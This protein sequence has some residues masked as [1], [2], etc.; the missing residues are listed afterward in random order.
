MAHVVESAIPYSRSL[1]QLLPVVPVSTRVQRPTNLVLK[2]HPSSTQTV[3][4]Y[5]LTFSPVKSV[6]TLWAI[7]DP[8]LAA[9]IERWHQAAVQDALSFIERHALSCGSTAGR[10]IRHQ[11]GPLPG[12]WTG[13]GQDPASCSA[14]QSD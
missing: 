9:Q 4:D 7:A 2:I 6:A 3:A 11:F 10:E 1:E 14:R 5:D 8:H 12:S 13:L